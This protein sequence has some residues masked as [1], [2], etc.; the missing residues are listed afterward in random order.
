MST[1][2]EL[3]DSLDDNSHTLLLQILWE[4]SILAAR[5]AAPEA[6][7]STGV[8]GVSKHDSTLLPSARL[9]H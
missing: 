3:C 5:R 6:S 2:V 7:D 1:V 8:S 4:V 9:T